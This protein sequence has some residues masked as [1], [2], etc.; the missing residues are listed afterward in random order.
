MAARTPPLPVTGFVKVAVATLWHAPTSPREVDAPALR[1]PVDIRGWLAGMTLSQKKALEGRVDSQMLL[2]DRVVVDSTSG[3]WAHVTVPDQP[4][5]ADARGYPGWVPLA[6]LTFATPSTDPIAVVVARTAWLI[7]PRDGRRVMEVSMGTRLQVK[8]GRPDFVVVTT[9]DDGPFKIAHADVLVTAG[10]DPALPATGAD[11]LRTARLFEGLPYLWGGASGFGFDCSGLTWLVYRLH[12]VTL[13]RD[14]DAQATAGAPV[15]RD[16]LRPGDLLFYANHA[17]VHH[18]SMNVDAARMIQSPRTG[19]TVEV[20][21]MD[22][23]PYAA[24][25]IGARRYLG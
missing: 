1:V 16:A 19:K 8:E 25:F 24:Q 7:D 4:N 5:P 3:D 2:G 14:A 20:V 10:G 15:A 12:G 18:V 17:P 6:Q 9:A 22:A 13:P 21:P 23:K 11:V